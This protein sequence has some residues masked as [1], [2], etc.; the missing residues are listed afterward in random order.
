MTPL[1]RAAP[2]A[3][4]CIGVISCAAFG[5]E[6]S[7]IDTPAPA[8]ASAETGSADGGARE[9][10][11]ARFPDAA[12]VWSGNGHAYEVVATESSW[13]VARTAAVERG[14][15]LAT[16]GSDEENLFV[17]S[18]VPAAA[19]NGKAGP[20]LGGLQSTLPDG[21]RLATDQGW[22]WIVASEPWSIASWAPGEPNDRF[23]KSDE[24][25]LCYYSGPMWSDNGANDVRPGYV[26]EYE[27]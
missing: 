13:T 7:S 24:Q 21:G 6:S 17:W 22:Q 5:V 16:L 20:W 12:T 2:A 27:P 8:D 9:R 26:V 11:A 25:Y 10:D 15:H 23:D 18:L 4:G 19:Q 3:L 1:L 14:G